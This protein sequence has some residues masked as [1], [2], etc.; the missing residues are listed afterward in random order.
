[1]VKG[2]KRKTSEG[3]GGESLG[4]RVYDEKKKEG[5]GDA[6]VT[7]ISKTA[8]ED[9]KSKRPQGQQEVKKQESK[10]LGLVD[11][12]SDDSDDD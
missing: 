10:G 9:E 12:G 11:Y 2:L 4:A 1:M 3:G 5:P 8:G 7:S 6:E